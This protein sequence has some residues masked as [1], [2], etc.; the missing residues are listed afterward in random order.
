LASDIRNSPAADADHQFGNSPTAGRCNLFSSHTGNFLGISRKTYIEKR[1]NSRR[2]LAVSS[3]H[4][5]H[6]QFLL[7]SQSLKNSGMSVMP[8]GIAVVVDRETHVIC[9]NLDQGQPQLDGVAHAMS[10]AISGILE[11]P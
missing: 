11:A 9:I 1:N 7:V 10:E 2:L 3:S 4:G 5:F 6:V 8:A